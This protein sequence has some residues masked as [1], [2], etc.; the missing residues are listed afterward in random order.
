MKVE[1]DKVIELSLQIPS[2]ATEVVSERSSILGR[3]ANDYNHDASIKAPTENRRHTRI[4]S[5]LCGTVIVL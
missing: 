3:G 1:H 4:R 2:G 5:T